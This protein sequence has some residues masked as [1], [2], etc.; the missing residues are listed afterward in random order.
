MEHL[1]VSTDVYVPPSEVCDF[2]LDFGG[3]ARY[4]D[5]L[6]SVDQ[7]GDGTGGTVRSEVTAVDPPPHTG[8]TGACSARSAPAVRG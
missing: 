7:E 1:V 2:L 3:C 5:Y 4:S 8:S 6:A